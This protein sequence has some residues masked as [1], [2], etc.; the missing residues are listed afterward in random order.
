MRQPVPGVALAPWFVLGTRRLVQAAILIAVISGCSGAIDRPGSSMDNGSSGSPGGP[1]GGVGG[2]AGGVG[3]GGAD[4]GGAGGGSGNGGAGGGIG[5]PTAG[6]PFS[7]T[8]FYV[9]PD[10]KLEVERSAS[11]HPE[12]AALLRK[13]EAYPTAIWLDSMSRLPLVGRTLDDALAQQQRLG[14]LVVTVFV[15]YDL[16]NRDCAALAS[17]GELSVDANGLDI[18]EHQ[19]IDPIAAALA[20]H[21][22][23]RI[24]LLI[25]PDSLGNIATNLSVPRCAAS[26]STYR[27]AV[28]Y[29][30]ATLAA[31]NT[32]LYLDAAHSGWLGW[33]DNLSKISTIFQQVLT[34]AGGASVI[35]GFATD[36]ANYSV[37]TTVTPE[38]FDYQGNPC[39]DELTYVDHLRSALAAV[40]ITNKGFLIDTSRSGRGGIRHEWGSWCNVR[41]A[42]LGLRPAADP[43]PGLDAYLWMKPPG[44]SDGTSDSTAPRFDAHC[45]NQ[46]ATPGAPQ[47]GQWFDAYFVDLVHN[48]TPP[49]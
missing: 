37:L 25:E 35:R 44:E 1:T 18:Y 7:G 4:G 40:G 41:G 2:G 33:P 34:A 49:L 32:F 17:N 36:L 31:P 28:A 14:Q 29:A 39:H 20:A 26:E 6:N 19:Y 23:Q 15:V 48:A 12:D 13:A 8:V 9:N 10:W 38:L 43:M 16:P 3:S 24:V 5:V 11:A 47:A 22:N 46:D 42:A 21:P 27:A 45:A 30:L